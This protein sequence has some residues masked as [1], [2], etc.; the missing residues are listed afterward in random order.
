MLR[1]DWLDH[2]AVP[3]DRRAGLHFGNVELETHTLDAELRRTSQMPTRSPRPPEPKGLDPPL[4]RHRPHEADDANDVIGVQVR[5]ENVL[6]HERDAVAHHLPLRP[7]AAIEQ[8]RL[9]LA[10]ER[11]RAD[12]ALDGGPGSGGAEEAEA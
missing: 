6:E 7:F 5:E 2:V 11:E 8:H 4:Q 9:S 10:D 1:G 3:L 12:V